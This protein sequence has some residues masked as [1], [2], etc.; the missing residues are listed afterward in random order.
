MKQI[1]GSSNAD[2]QQAQFLAARI[3][4]AGSIILF[5]ISAVVGLAT[6]SVTLILDASA[7]LVILVVGFLMYFSIKKIHQPPD[8]LYN[9]GYH[10]YEPLTAAVQ[11]GM[12]IVVCVVSIKFAIQDIIHA[13]DIHSYSLAVFSTFCAGILGTLITIYLKS[14]ARKTGSQMIKASSAH[15][16]IDTVLSFGVCV[17][18]CL[19]LLIKNSSWANITP[20][21]D[22]GMA[23]LL[24][25]FFISS[26]I[27]GGLENLFELLDQAPVSGV[28]AR[29]KEIVNQYKPDSFGVH[30]LRIR[31]AGQKV[32]IDACF[33]V[34][35]NL[36]IVE[37]GEMAESFERNL[38]AHL[39]ECDV[40]VHFKSKKP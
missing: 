26:P 35:D 31:K 38:R 18:F 40:V 14:I 1:S 8:D 30:R 27:K 22:P 33:A 29:I 10:K 34:D 4:I 24:A 3:S 17:G 23:I 25:V 20:Y 39:P 36:T 7:S 37:A 19:A 2:K 11:N 13:E 32:F 9:F 15:W 21:I 12:I 16:F 28:S 5:L 6:D